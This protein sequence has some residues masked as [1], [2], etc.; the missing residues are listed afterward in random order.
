[1]FNLSL[2]LEYKIQLLHRTEGL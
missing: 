1:M 2:M